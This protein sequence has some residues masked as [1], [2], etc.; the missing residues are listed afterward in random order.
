MKVSPQISIAHVGWLKC[1]RTFRLQ[2]C[3]LPLRKV[4]PGQTPL[5]G[6]LF[7]ASWVKAWPIWRGPSSAKVD[8]LLCNSEQLCSAFPKFQALPFHWFQLDSFWAITPMWAG[9]EE[10]G[11]KPH[12]PGQEWRFLVADILSLSN[13]SVIKCNQRTSSMA[14]WGKPGRW[15][16]HSQTQQ[17]GL[18]FFP[19]FFWFLALAAS[20]FSQRET[21]GMKPSDEN[22]PDSQSQVLCLCLPHHLSSNGKQKFQTT[23]IEPLFLTE[24][25]E[26]NKD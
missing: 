14:W 5:L 25:Q 8:N 18:G 2:I 11:A 23:M 22:Y 1:Q 10:R 13:V 16:C 21:L 9:L 17:F 24:I 3:I 7:L 15:R 4:L 19:F 26:T 6:L 12:G 20:L